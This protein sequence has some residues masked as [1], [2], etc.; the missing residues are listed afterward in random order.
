MNAVF[1][2]TVKV[3]DGIIDPNITAINEMDNSFITSLGFDIASI[4][5]L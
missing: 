2:D 1:E 4:T 3:L 5:A